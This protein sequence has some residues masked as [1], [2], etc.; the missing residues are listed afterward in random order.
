MVT[1][2]QARAFVAAELA[3]EWPAQLGTF[4]VLARGYEDAEVFRV[5]V[6]AREHLIDGD[7]DFVEF[8]APTI[9]V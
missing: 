2:H 8:D 3:A 6:G 1:F 7:A 4:H 9:I 5:I